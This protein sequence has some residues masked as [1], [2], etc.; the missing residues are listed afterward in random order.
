[1]RLVPTN[2][3]EDTLNKY[4]ELWNKIRNLITSI[5][6]NS[7]HYDGKYI[8]IKFNSDDDLSLKKTLE[9]A[10]MIVAARAVFDEGNKYY[11]QVFLDKY[12][13]KL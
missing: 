10:K 3:S 11:S 9:F 5:T 6:N 8:K 1:M 13:F 12:L 7:D 4:E 2:E